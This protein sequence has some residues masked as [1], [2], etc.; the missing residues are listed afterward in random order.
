MKVKR[1][2]II[3][4]S[5]LFLSSA[6]IFSG[7]GTVQDTTSG[8]IFTDPLVKI[9]ELSDPTFVSKI[10]YEAVALDSNLDA[11]TTQVHMGYWSGPKNTSLRS[12]RTNLVFVLDAINNYISPAGAPLN[13]AIWD[14]GATTSTSQQYPSY[15][16]MNNEHWYE[17]AFPVSG[18]VSIEGVYYDDP[19][20]VTPAQADQIWGSYSQRYAEM[21]R[22]FKAT[23]GMSVEARCFVQGA[24]APRI[25][26]TFELPDLVSLEAEGVVRVFFALTSEAKWDAPADWIEGTTN[27]P[28]PES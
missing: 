24:R 17:R 28:T 20:P 11:P 2:L 21:A 23:T 3:V 5:I 19:H 15:I 12:N 8:P 14:E 7:C 25:F 1:F 4:C 18:K 22:L 13:R 9:A 6:I 26:Y 27:A 10:F 16:T